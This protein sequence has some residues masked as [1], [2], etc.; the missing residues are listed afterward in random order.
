MKIAQHNKTPENE[1]LEKLLV[2]YRDTP[3][4]ATGCDTL[5][6][7]IPRWTIIPISSASCH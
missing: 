2:N 1:A 7:A 3:H 6:N 5:S 4:P